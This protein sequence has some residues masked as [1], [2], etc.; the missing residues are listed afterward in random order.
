MAR[1]LG[2]YAGA[3][4]HTVQALMTGMRDWEEPHPNPW[5]FARLAWDPERDAAPLLGEFCTA[6]W[7]PE[8]GTER[9]ERLAE[10]ER[11][12]AGRGHG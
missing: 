6:M 4:A 8:E 7:G 9:A 5:A 1:D 11:R 3:G 12:V 2:F 10:Q